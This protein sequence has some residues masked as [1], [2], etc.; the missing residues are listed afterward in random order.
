[1]HYNKRL[2]KQEKIWT[3]RGMEFIAELGWKSCWIDKTV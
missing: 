1:M 2:Q 3:P